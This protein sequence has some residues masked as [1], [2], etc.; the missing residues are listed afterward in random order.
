MNDD[1]RLYLPN[2]CS[3]LAAESEY[4]EPL[5]LHLDMPTRYSNSQQYSGTPELDNH[6]ITCQE[7]ARQYRRLCNGS[8]ESRTPSRMLRYQCP[9]R[10]TSGYR[11]SEPDLPKTTVFA[12]ALP[13]VSGSGSLG[14][15]LDLIELTLF[16]VDAAAASA[17]HRN[18]WKVIISTLA[19]AL[20]LPSL[21]PRPP[22]YDPYSPLLNLLH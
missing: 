15:S 2:F 14:M 21:I 1:E 6:I 16:S 3:M 20:L 5:W 22:L 10:N 8:G 9:A 11:S 7:S 19:S 4:L 12:S 18:P 17:A 13:L